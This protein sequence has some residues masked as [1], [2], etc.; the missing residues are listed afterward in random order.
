MNEI[1]NRMLSPAFGLQENR[2]RR[3][4]AGE[5]K[6]RL[7]R[8]VSP[9][10]SRAKNHSAAGFPGVEKG[11]DVIG[12]GVSVIVQVG[13]A[14]FRVRHGR[15]KL[16]AG[17]GGGGVEDAED[18]F[19]NAGVEIGGGVPPLPGHAA[20]EGRTPQATRPASSPPENYSSLPEVGPGCKGKSAASV[21]F[22]VVASRVSLRHP[23]ES[24]NK[25]DSS[26]PGVA[27]NP[28]GGRACRGGPNGYRG[29]PA[30]GISPTASV[31]GGP[32]GHGLIRASAAETP[33]RT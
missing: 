20:W 29:V 9:G 4:N 27:M 24:T 15:F 6:K 11:D 2:K 21:D 28:K 33:A 13:W 5:P 22:S 1:Q 14:E 32:V 31:T 18:Q 8:P 30:F 26:R 7:T 23:R 12:V 17:R 25:A 10:V 16:R 3:K 19:V